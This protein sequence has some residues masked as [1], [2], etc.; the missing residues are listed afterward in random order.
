[1]QQNETH[2]FYGEHVF[3]HTT[4]N[5]EIW[6][7][8]EAGTWYSESYS[9]Q[10]YSGDLGGVVEKLDYFSELGVTILY[11]NPIF[12]SPSNHRYDT[13]DFMQIDPSLGTD[14]TFMALIDGAHA[15]N[16][17]VVLDGVF[18]HASSDSKYFDRYHQWDNV[19]GAC[20]KDTSEYRNW[21]T[22]TPADPA[23]S[24]V[25]GEDMEY[26][27]WWGFDSLAVFD[28]M[29]N[30]VR[31]YFWSSGQQSVALYWLARGIGMSLLFFFFLS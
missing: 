31:D 30:D 29:N 9:N 5:E 7:P 8:Y 2:F 18:N 27:A 26:K 12:S 11:L 16:M 25:C 19:V 1:L 21:F 28:S 13:S 17:K 6:D 24:G 23:G 22:F 15:R 10:F 20:E 4:W 14:D 3:R